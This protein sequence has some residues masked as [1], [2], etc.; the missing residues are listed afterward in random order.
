VTL[1]AARARQ[2]AAADAERSRI[3]RALHDG[4]QQDLIAVAVRLQLARRL[5]ASD[6]PAALELL[7]ELG[8]DVRDALGRVRVLAGEIYPSLLEARGLP[9]ALRA[10]A[11]ALGVP[12]RVDA[13]GVGRQS[14]ELEAAIYF[15]GRA[16]LENV[17]AY[18]GSGA[19]A[20]IRLHQDGDALRL[21]VG[22]DGVGFDP[23]LDPAGGG[24]TGARD[25]VEA[26]GGELA[27]E[28]APGRGTSIAATVPLKPS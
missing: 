19:R 10:S 9:D 14:A 23:A 16:A 6:L 1:H 4:V 13:A 17:A 21:E 22:D 8:R 24:L 7:D 5:A 25:R 3:E 20:T 2:A 26:F 11:S 28:S 18:A 15:C 12:V 27:I